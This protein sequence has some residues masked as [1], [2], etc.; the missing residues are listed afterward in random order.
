MKT[1]LAIACVAGLGSACAAQTEPEAAARKKAACVNRNPLRNLYFG[2]LHVHTSYSFDAQIFETRNNPA[3]AYRFAKGE[4]IYS[5]PMGPDGKGTQE[6]RLPRPLDFAAVTDHSEFL[7][8]VESCTTPGASG[9]DSERCEKYR[10]RDLGS[11]AL[12][13]FLLT[14]GQPQR[15]ANLCG[16]DG[17]VCLSAA[18]KVWKRIVSFADEAYDWSSECKFTSL[19]AYEYTAVPG[20]SNL[21]RN[22]I[23]RGDSVPA[24]PVSYFEEPQAEGLW[25]RLRQECNDAGTG[26]DVLAIPHNSNL[27]NGKMFAVETGDSVA[28]RADRNKLRTSMEPLV[29]ITQHKGE[30]ECMNGFSGTL[31]LTD[32]FCEAE[33][34][35]PL[36]TDCG[37]G[38]GAGGMTG[39]GCQSHNDFVRG[40]LL[41][42]L[43]EEDKTGVN[44]FQMGF[45]AS[46]DT[47]NATPGATEERLFKGHVGSNDDTPEKRLAPGV[48]PASFLSANPGG[49]A[50]VWAEENSRESIFDALRRR[51]TYGT[52]GTRIALRVFG[53]W[54]YGAKICGDPALV[55]K[56][57]DGGVPMGSV[58]PARPSGAKAPM[59]LISALRDPGYDGNAGTP[60]QRLQ[61]VKGWIEGGERHEKV[62]DVAGNPN[63]GAG[64]DA[65]CGLTGSGFD[66][67]CTV[68]TDPDFS[69][70]LRAFY[71]VRAIENPSC[72]WNQWQCL[73][74]PAAKR[75]ASCDADSPAPKTIQERAW[76]SPLWFQP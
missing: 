6:Q 49:L 31:G 75:P 48:F 42:G 43:Q 30:S 74:L 12:W 25:K 21:H 26:C 33:K 67:L 32:E 58:L 41:T 64:V 69:P 72:R 17:K 10:L 60:L 76:S 19:V 20:L 66:S 39:L 46:T 9:Y 7:G 59:L 51:E 18:G 71:Y 55:Q 57:Y 56:G 3:D 34:V 44:P 2:D 4:S 68:W 27:S 11:F 50:A 37:E 70:T 61:V 8:E 45:I 15:F 62:Y 53:G 22:V 52:S 65:A 16:A 40:A 28:V 73:A 54:Q 35:V 63:N 47:H 36:N 38:T 14:S 1:W 5:S 29:E 13:G 23:F 24:E